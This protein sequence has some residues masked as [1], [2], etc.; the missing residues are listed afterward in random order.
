MTTALDDDIDTLVL[1]SVMKSSTRL[2]PIELKQRL[3]KTL[4][5]KRD[6]LAS[7]I[8]RLVRQR[9]L[10]YT[11]QFGNTFLEP[12]FNKAVRITDSIVLKPPESKF[13]EAEKD[14]VLNIR[15]GAAFGSGQHPTT[16]L[17]LKALE[18]VCRNNSG[19]MDDRQTNVLDIGTGSG[20]LLIAALKLGMDEGIG[21]DIDPCALA[22]ARENVKLNHLERRVDIS[23]QAFETLAGSFYMVIANLRLPTL[24]TYFACMLERVETDGFLITSGIKSNEI[25]SLERLGNVSGLEVIWKGVKNEWAALV[26]RRSKGFGGE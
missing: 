14:V 23:S 5:L 20:V 19:L 24:K 3:K 9:E 17:S 25:N 26:L 22:E 21:L 16:R 4:P 10:V 1:E 8:K 6:Q 7:S 13:I 2:T 11:Y 18:M 12:C 15:T